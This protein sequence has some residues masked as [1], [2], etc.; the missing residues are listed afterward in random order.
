MVSNFL[1]PNPFHKCLEQF[2][3]HKEVVQ[4]IWLRRDLVLHE[5]GSIG[6]EDDAAIAEVFQE[7]M[8]AL[9]RAFQVFDHHGGA[10]FTGEPIRALKNSNGGNY[11]LD[12]YFNRQV[13]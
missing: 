1:R 9:D 11:S 7:L 8:Q 4:L 3:W 10:L 2:R 5:T 12:V 13:F 6:F